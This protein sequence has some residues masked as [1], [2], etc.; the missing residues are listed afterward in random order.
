[1]RSYNVHE[2]KSNLSRLLKEVAGGEK[3]VIMRDGKPVAELVPYRE[4]RRKKRRLGFDTAPFE[5]PEG[6]ER[7]M[8]DE[9]V[10]AFLGG[11]L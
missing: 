9:E 11:K 10:D 1:M 5:M 4:P 8:T 2:A 6:W 3:V 7:P